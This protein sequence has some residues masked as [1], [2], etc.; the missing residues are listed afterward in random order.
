MQAIAPGV[1]AV[2]RQVANLV[3]V[4]AKIWRHAS[5]DR[6]RIQASNHATSRASFAT[7]AM[8]ID[9]ETAGVLSSAA[10]PADS[11]V[12]HCAVDWRPH[13]ATH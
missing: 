12:P 3:G 2:G 7:A 5:C 4:D 6:D 13:R 10:A 8:S 11:I 9:G 1:R